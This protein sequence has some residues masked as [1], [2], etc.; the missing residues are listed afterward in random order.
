MNYK[1][2]IKLKSLINYLNNHYLKYF[3]LFLTILFLVTNLVF[4]PGISSSNTTFVKIATLPQDSTEEQI[5]PLVLVQCLDI[6]FSPA[7]NFAVGTTPVSVAIGDIDGDGKQD[8]AIANQGSNSVSILRN[9]SSVASASFD[10]TDFTVGMLPVSVAIGDIDGDGKKDLAVVNQNSSNVSVLRNT[11]NIGLVSFAPAVNS[12]AGTTPSSVTIGDIDGDGKLDLAVANGGSNNAS[13]LRNTSSIGLVSFAPAISFAAGTFPILIATSD[14][15]A[16]GKKDLAVVNQNS[17]NVSVLRNTSSIGSVSFAPASNFMVGAA[18]RSVTIGDIDGDGKLDLAVANG[19]FS[20]NSVS[21][22]RNIGDVGSL[23]FDPAS[24]FSV[25]S[26]PFSVAM[27][28]LDGDNK[29]DLIAA[30]LGSHT[31]SILRNISSVGSLVFDPANNFPVGLNPAAIAVGDID[32]DNKLDLNIVNVTDNNISALLNTCTSI[33]CPT[34]T[35]TPTILSGGAVGISY[36]QTLTA[37]GGVAP[38]T[39]ALST[40]SLPPGLTLNSS[41]LL[42]GTPT[43]TGTFNF[44]IQVTDANS[45]VGTRSYT[46]TIITCSTI[47]ISPNSLP[48]ATVGIPYSKQLTASGGN[49]PYTFTLTAGVLPPGLALSTTGLISG[50]ATVTGNFNFTVRATDSNGC[51]KNKSYTIRSRN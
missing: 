21:V 9:T 4:L 46:L 7:T 5:N 37:S 28:D 33:P 12:T 3:L 26:Q 31:I 1:R 43:T 47:T 14:I 41:G 10:R 11:S 35:I 25:G 23:V 6:N 40:G 16:D 34:I 18:P 49:S 38:Y 32:G 22:L 44:T 51:I 27:G 29:L 13:I 50:T 42:S 17:S 20:V 24:N 48:N 45:C 30:N 36:N 15:D 2:E 8:L 39:Y 19:A